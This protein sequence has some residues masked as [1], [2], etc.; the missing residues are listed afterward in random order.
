MHGEP[1]GAFRSTGAQRTVQT[2]RGAPLA[3]GAR[4]HFQKVHGAPLTTQKAHGAAHPEKR[5][6]HLSLLHVRSAIA[7]G[8]TKAVTKNRSGYLHAV[9]LPQLDFAVNS[10]D[11]LCTLLMRS[12]PVAS[13]TLSVARSRPNFQEF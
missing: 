12:V 9:A 13:A 1:H 5:T 7:G 6:V 8:L 10:V 3:K 4:R 11:A 2:V